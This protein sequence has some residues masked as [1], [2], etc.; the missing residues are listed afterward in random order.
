MNVELR[1]KSV[2]LEM[3]AVGGI[4]INLAAEPERGKGISFFV[5]RKG[6]RLV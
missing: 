6:K 4:Y 3:T 5:L 1:G 2:F